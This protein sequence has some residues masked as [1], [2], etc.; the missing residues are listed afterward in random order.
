MQTRCPSKVWTALLVVQVITLVAGTVL[1]DAP[2]AEDPVPKL[3]QSLSS[4]DSGEVLRAIKTLGRSG[5]P[6]AVE[7]LI[8]ILTSKMHQFIKLKAIDSLAEIGDARAVPAL[9][10]ELKTSPTPYVPA[11]ALHMIGSADAVA[12]LLKLVSTETGRGRRWAVHALGFLKARQATGALIAILEDK[13]APRLLRAAA[14]GALERIADPSVTEALHTAMMREPEDSLLHYHC[15]RALAANGDPRAIP[16]LVKDMNQR[17]GASSLSA[18]A[19]AVFGGEKV[20]K[21]VRPLL[22]H[23]DVQVRTE[24]IRLLIKLGDQAIVDRL[25]KILQSS[26]KESMRNIATCGLCQLKARKAVKPLSAILTDDSQ[27][28]ELRRLIAN[29]IGKIGDARAVPALEAAAKSNDSYLPVSA[30]CSLARLNA[31]GAVDRMIALLKNPNWNIRAK[32]TYEIGE[33]GLQDQIPVVINALR[34]DTEDTVCIECVRVLFKFGGTEAK[35][36]IR[37]AVKHE[38]YRVSRIARSA[39][40]EMA[41]RPATRPRP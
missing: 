33:I 40:R 13:Q 31:K 3:I 19:L 28:I 15:A 18:S 26:G 30:T 39:L 41:S 17:G 25:L 24:A 2:P 10:E 23:E 22:D 32:I 38:S 11:G 21:S 4:R 5:D 7:P 8:N 20:I 37:E 14:A 16:I 36:A 35:A 34:N 9:V 6:R 12:P 27:P 29:H 1:A